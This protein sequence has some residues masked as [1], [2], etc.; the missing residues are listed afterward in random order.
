MR[1]HWQKEEEKADA[2]SK[3]ISEKKKKDATVLLFT[4]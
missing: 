2:N 1:S 3:Q 4:S